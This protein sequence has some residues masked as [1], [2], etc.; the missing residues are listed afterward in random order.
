MEVA[1]VGKKAAEVLVGAMVGKLGQEVWVVQGSEVAEEAKTAEELPQ[2]S[3][4]PIG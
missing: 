2:K 3:A 1:A 4:P